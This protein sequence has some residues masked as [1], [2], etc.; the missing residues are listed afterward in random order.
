MVTSIAIT[1]IDRRGGLSMGAVPFLQ[2]G[3]QLCSLCA[4]SMFRACSWDNPSSVIVP[5]LAIIIMLICPGQ[6]GSG[7]AL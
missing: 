2:A 1:D 3:C 4:I 7:F 5:V 6:H